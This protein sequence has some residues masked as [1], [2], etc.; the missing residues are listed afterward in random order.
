[1]TD[2]RLERAAV[3][4][5]FASSVLWAGEVVA[6]DEDGSSL[7]EFTSFV[8][9]DAHGVSSRLKNSGQGEFRLDPVRSA[10]DPDHCLAFPDNLEL[11]STLTWVGDE[12][13]SLVR[14]VTPEASSITLVRSARR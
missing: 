8:V 9:R 1:M 6:L 4:Q 3:A 10:L 11:Q 2:D 12:P 7:V 14:G 13:G 5:S